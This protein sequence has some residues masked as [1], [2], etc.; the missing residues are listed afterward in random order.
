MSGR[1]RLPDSRPSDAAPLSA[2][3]RAAIARETAKYPPKRAAS[4]VMA[5]LRIAQRE[6]GWLSR[7]TIEVVA[8]QLEIPPIRALEVATFYNM[9]DLRPVGR[10]KLCVCTNL[11]CA[12]RGA[13]ETAAALRTALGVGFDETTPDGEFTLTEGECFG[14]C[15]MAPAVIV[16]NERM[17]GP[18]PPEKTPALLDGL[19]REPNSNRAPDIPGIPGM[20]DIIKNGGGGR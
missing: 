8:G 13:E 1:P 19:R 6:R 20:A 17:L 9:Y 2:A 18:V 12:L 4:A 7:E 3:A 14:S 16:N 15:D 10:W 5:A 11:P